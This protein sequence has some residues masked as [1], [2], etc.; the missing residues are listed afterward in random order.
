MCQYDG[1]KYTAVA[2]INAIGKVISQIKHGATMYGEL[3]P[4]LSFKKS[5]IYMRGLLK[6][7]LALDVTSDNIWDYQINNKEFLKQ[8]NIPG[9]S[10]EIDGIGEINLYAGA[11]GKP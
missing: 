4:N 3:W 6:D 11:H 5:Y 10:Y 7:D 1:S 9:T 2:D 8:F